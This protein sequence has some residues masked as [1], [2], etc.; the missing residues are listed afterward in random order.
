MKKVDFSQNP[1]AEEE[2]QYFTDKNGL[3]YYFYSGENNVSVR[4]LR[5][6]QD[7]LSLTDAVDGNGCIEY[8]SGQIA[9]D[10]MIKLSN[11][12]TTSVATFVKQ[13]IGSG[14]EHKITIRFL[15]LDQETEEEIEPQL[16]QA[17]YILSTLSEKDGKEILG[18]KITPVDIDYANSNGNVE[19]SVESEY[20]LIDADGIEVPEE[21]IQYD[22]DSYR[23]RTRMYHADTLPD[24]YLDA[25]SKDDSV[26]G[27]D[28]IS[29]EIATN[30]LTS[31]IKLH[32]AYEKDYKVRLRFD[33]SSP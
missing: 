23:L 11:S 28:F 7:A 13:N 25:I 15:G 1:S 10:C 12:E 30:G 27:Y 5:S 24:N 4:M 32:K 6:T 8:R 31:E 3:G 2:I 26:P 17:Y 20:Q 21:Y 33:P 22:P 16:E 14:K 9:E 29:N 18:Y 19:V